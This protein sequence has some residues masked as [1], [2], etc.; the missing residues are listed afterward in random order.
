MT[1]IT[2]N[3]YGY[4]IKAST[5]S[6][7]VP[8]NDMS[9][10][11]N[12]Y[13]KDKLRESII[14]ELHE[15]DGDTIDLEKYPDSFDELVDEVFVDLSDKIDNEGSFPNDDDIRN[16]IADVADYYEMDI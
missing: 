10:L 6:M 16:K 1:T 13:M 2:R 8:H 5:Y 14:Y 3:E 4:E 15:A 11:V 12:T 7:I 9:L